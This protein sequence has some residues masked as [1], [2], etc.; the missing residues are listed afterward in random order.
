MKPYIGHWHLTRGKDSKA[1]LPGEISPEL[2]DKSWGAR[3][4]MLPIHHDTAS[5][6][7]KHT[8]AVTNSTTGMCLV[9]GRRDGTLAYLDPPCDGSGEV[10][11]YVA[12]P[13]PRLRPPS[14]ASR[15][16]QIFQPWL[17]C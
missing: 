9:G 4:C 16:L 7:C 12:S 8:P 5:G 14:E 3:I 11:P 6:W 10:T 1:L 17:R 15:R 13:D 2:F